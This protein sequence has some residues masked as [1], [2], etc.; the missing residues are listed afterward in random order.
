VTIDLSELQIPSILVRKFDVNVEKPENIDT[1]SI[2]LATRKKERPLQVFT[3]VLF[4]EVATY[5][6]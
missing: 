1:E 5:N 3:D 2:F 4:L 6:R